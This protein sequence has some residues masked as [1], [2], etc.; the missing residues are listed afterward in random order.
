M[1]TCSQGKSLCEKWDCVQPTPSTAECQK[2]GDVNCDDLNAC[3]LDSCNP[4]TGTCN[5]IQRTDC[6]DSN[7]CTVD[8]CDISSGC[9]FTNLNEALTCTQQPGSSDICYGSPQ[10][11]PCNDN[12][13]C[14]NEYCSISTGGCVRS[15]VVCPDRPCFTKSCDPSLGC[16]YTA[17]GM[18][19]L[20]RYI[21]FIYLG[22][23]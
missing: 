17:V 21:Y 3:T 9:K 13:L 6:V 8:T 4:A 7:P 15:D 1:Q 22:L 18:S 14:T 12:N 23:F 5:N 20:S 11:T 10:G 2:V 19:L 16:V